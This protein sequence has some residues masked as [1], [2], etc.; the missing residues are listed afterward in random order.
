MKPF[1][2]PDMINSYAMVSMK[3][4][5]KGSSLPSHLKWLCPFYHHHLILFCLL[6]NPLEREQV[7]YGRDGHKLAHEAKFGPN[8]GL[9]RTQEP[10]LGKVSSSNIYWTFQLFGSAARLLRLN[11]WH[12]FKPLVLPLL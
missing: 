8:L 11:G 9:L 5:S 7:L 1:P 2:C 6:T 10:K 3:E 4:H 12:P